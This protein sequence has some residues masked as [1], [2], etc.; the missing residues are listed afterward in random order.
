MPRLTPL[1]RVALALTSLLVLLPLLIILGTYGIGPVTVIGGAP[2]DGT[3]IA[4]VVVGAIFITL[5]GLAVTGWN[6]LHRVDVAMAELRAE[7]EAAAKHA[8]KPSLGQRV[9]AV[10][11]VGV[12]LYLIHWLMSEGMIRAVRALFE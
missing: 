3:L 6:P 11:V 8:P 10:V 9:V 2:S 5:L 4:G 7:A 1:L 12:A